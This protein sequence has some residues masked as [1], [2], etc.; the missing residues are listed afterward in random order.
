MPLIFHD[1]IVQPST[2]YLDY[3]YYTSLFENDL[4]AVIP[5]SFLLI[6]SLIVLLYGVFLSNSKDK[7]YPILVVNASIISILSLLFTIILLWNNPISRATIFY[8]NL[9]I[10][11]LA[12]FLKI[13]ILLGGLFSIAMSLQYIQNEGL[14]QFELQLLILLSSVSMLF[15]V[16]AADFIT[17]YLAIELQ[18]L[19]FYV[20][21][22]VK[23]DSEFSTEAGLKYFLLGAFSSGILLFGLALLY[24]FTGTTHFSEVSKIFICGSDSLRFGFSSL[25]G[26]ELGMVFILVGFLFKLTAVPFHMWAPDVYEG[27]PTSVTAFF[28]IVPKVSV[29]AVLLRLCYQGFYDFMVPWQKM[30]IL[31]SI[32]SMVLGSLAALSQN[33]IK[34]LLAWSSIGHVGYLLIAIS[35]GTVEGIQAILIYLVIYLVMTIALFAVVLCPLRREKIS[36]L[37]S[38]KLEI[39]RLKYLTDFALLSKTNPVIAITIMIT[40][41]SIA[42]IPPLAG[43]Y[44]KAYLMFA[45]MSASQYLLAVVAILTSVISCFY[46]IRIVKIIYFEK[47]TTLLTFIQI[48]KESSLVLAV[49]FTFI[50]F[51]CLN[52]APLFLAT[53]KTALAFCF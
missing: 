29:L 47:P 34:R 8:N 51:F 17:M 35:C 39:S 14:N 41:F 10:D 4:K 40:M 24:G 1:V 27:A 5:E 19:A 2:N 37:N 11:D 28:A 21:A 16:S 15:L 20:M 32:A 7:N 30:L 18:S 43:F 23:R 31:S 9:L 42:G 50:L 53:H 49:T 12:L 45:A 33:K 22:G 3:N 52:P 48:S 6:A 26:C 44:S 36:S 25:R 38:D 46:Y 13:L